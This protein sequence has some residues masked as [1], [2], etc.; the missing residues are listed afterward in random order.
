MSV[1]GNYQTQQPLVPIA[2]IGGQK[3]L[4]MGGSL[5]NYINTGNAYIAENDSYTTQ[6]N[7][8]KDIKKPS[9][10]QKISSTGAPVVGYFIAGGVL[11]ALLV[12]SIISGDFTKLIKKTGS[13]ISNFAKK[14]YTKNAPK[15]AQFFKDIPTKFSGFIKKIFSKKP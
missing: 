10:A 13:S 1:L 12:K 11:A 6:K 2:D 14:S 7:N 5:T 15:I 8:Q 4:K 3:V 9:V